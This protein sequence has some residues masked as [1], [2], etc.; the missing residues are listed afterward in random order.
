MGANELRLWMGFPAWKLPEHISPVGMCADADA[1]TPRPDCFTM[2]KGGRLRQ[3]SMRW[4]DWG[5]VWNGRC[6]TARISTSSNPGKGCI[7]SDILM[8]D[9]EEKYS[10][11]EPEQSRRGRSAPRRTS[12]GA[13]ELRQRAGSP[14]WKLLEHIP[15]V[16]MCADG[17]AGR[18]AAADYQPGF[19]GA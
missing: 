13:N 4:T 10:G 11:L 2:T 16:G 8:K 15:P 5:M 7:L 19:R 17:N 18:N 6:L 14:A 3:S 12:V 9:A 1:G